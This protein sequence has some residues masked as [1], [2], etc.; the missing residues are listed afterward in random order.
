MFINIRVVR[1]HGTDWKSSLSFKYGIAWHYNYLLVC[2]LF[3]FTALALLAP[4]FTKKIPV[5]L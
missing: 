4:G 5:D 3:V 2:S 1:L